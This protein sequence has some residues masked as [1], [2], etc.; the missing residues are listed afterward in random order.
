MDGLKHALN[1]RMMQ[2]SSFRFYDALN[3]IQYVIMRMFILCLLGKR[4]GGVFVREQTR[5][6]LTIRSTP[7]WLRDGECRGSQHALPTI[8]TACSRIGRRKGSDG[9]TWRCGDAISKSQREAARGG[10]NT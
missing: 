6:F 4:R 5:C 8:L 9:Q 10:N 7:P 3:R 2:S 1:E